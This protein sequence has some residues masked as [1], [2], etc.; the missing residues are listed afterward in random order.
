MPDSRGT[1][2]KT[3]I[4][5]LEKVKIMCI[6]E[7]SRGTSTKTRIETKVRIWNIYIHEKFKRHIH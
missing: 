7:N 2:T 5:T 1:S 4:E 6:I 3:R